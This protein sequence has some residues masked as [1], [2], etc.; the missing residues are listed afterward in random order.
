MQTV[1]DREPVDTQTFC[2]A[3]DKAPRWLPVD[4]RVRRHRW[5]QHDLRYTNSV[6]IHH[7]FELDH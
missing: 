3:F 6:G 5:P 2:T 7:L 4:T 1:L